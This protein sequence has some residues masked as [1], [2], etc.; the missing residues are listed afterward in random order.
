V[1]VYD[2]V[3][4]RSLANNSRSRLVEWALPQSRVLEVGCAT[5]FMAEHLARE[6][7]CRVTGVEQDPDAARVAA[8]RCERLVVGDIEQ[9]EVIAQ[10]AGEYD[11]IVFADVLEHLR[12]PESVLRTLARFLAPDGRILASIPN[13]AHWSIRWRLLV[14]RWEYEDRGILDRTHL[15]F[16]TRRSA[17]ALFGRAGLAVTRVTGVWGFPRLFYP[18]DAAQ[19]WIAARW[20]GVFMIQFIIEAAGARP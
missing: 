1:T 17:L 19:S 15:R 4:D 18:P 5:G 14:G 8:G 2:G 20:P 13:V 11:V 12:D 7:G 3:V 16:F 6:L 10:C 9:P